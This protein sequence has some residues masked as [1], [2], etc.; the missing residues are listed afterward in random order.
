MEKGKETPFFRWGES[1][2][3]GWKVWEIPE[4]EKFGKKFR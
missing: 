3:L 4:G 2:N 1:S